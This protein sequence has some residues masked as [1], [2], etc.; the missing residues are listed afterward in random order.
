MATYTQIHYHIVFS[1]KNRERTLTT[2]K[3]ESLFRYVWG[4]IKNKKCHPYRINST[5]NHIHILTSLHPSICLSDFVK[6]I[7][8]STSRWIKENNLFPYFTNWQAGYGAFTHSQNEKNALIEYIK[9]QE[10]H[11]KNITFR[12]EYKNLLIDAGIEFDEKYL[13]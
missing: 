3:R 4:I 10:E 12:E 5:D 6:G 1:T 2:E 9:S 8:I 13:L 7:K 11:H